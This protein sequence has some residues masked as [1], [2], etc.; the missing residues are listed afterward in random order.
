MVSSKIIERRI[1]NEV[2]IRL[3]DLSKFNARTEGVDKGLEE[4]KAS[5]Q[6]IG[7]IHPI[8][9]FDKP[10][11]RYELI[12]G[13]RRLKAFESLGQKTIP[14]VIINNLDDISKKILSLTENIN[15]KNLPYMRTITLCDELFNLEKGSDKERIESISRKVGIS[16]Q[17][18]SK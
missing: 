11:G 12:A 7:L 15:R 8:V 1:D 14:A 10:D 4:L 18:V 17:T 3:I 16:L 6:R 13:Q 9:L 5:I 2:P